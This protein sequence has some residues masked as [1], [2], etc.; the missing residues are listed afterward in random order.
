VIEAPA[1]V[2]D[3][4]HARLA[5]RRIGIEK[6]VLKYGEAPTGI[7]EVFELCRGFE[8]A[9]VEFVNVSMERGSDVDCLPKTLFKG[10]GVGKGPRQSCKGEVWFSWIIQ[11]VIFI[12]TPQHLLLDD[13]HRSPQWPAK[14]G[15]CSW[16]RKG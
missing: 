16:G 4:L 2:L 13:T 3:V 8:R 10:M 1:A 12:P 9:Y 7:K 15:R 14:S 5:E 11:G 6:E